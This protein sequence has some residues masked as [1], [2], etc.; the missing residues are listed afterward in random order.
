[1]S[2]RKHKASQSCRQES[3]GSSEKVKKGEPLGAGEVSGRGP[4][5]PRAWSQGLH[6]PRRF[7]WGAEEMKISDTGLSSRRRQDVDPESVFVQPGKNYSVSPSPPY[8]LFVTHSIRK[9]LKPLG[10]AP[11]RRA[12]L[13]IP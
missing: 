10:A 12:A 11:H 1:M 7:P 13:P 8:R 6:P 3:T 4:R 2:K 5:G 9:A